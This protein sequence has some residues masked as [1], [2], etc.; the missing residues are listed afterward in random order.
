MQAN[1]FER[2][3]ASVEYAFSGNVATGS[4][5]VSCRSIASVSQFIVNFVPGTLSI[6]ILE[7]VGKVRIIASGDTT[8]R[9]CKLQMLMLGSS[10]GSTTLKTVIRSL[11]TNNQLLS[12]TPYDDNTPNL[13]DGSSYAT[14]GQASDDWWRFPAGE[15]E[16]W[17][18]SQVIAT[19]SGYNFDFF[20][21]FSNLMF[22]KYKVFYETGPGADYSFEMSGVKSDEETA[23]PVFPEADMTGDYIKASIYANS[24]GNDFYIYNGT[25]G[26]RY[27]TKIVGVN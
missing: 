18:G 1:A 15:V 27:I 24:G 16:L 21:G 26:N 2:F 3:E 6:D 22:K 14:Y 10:S 7:R 23:S 9:G 12:V 5:F 25:G 13:Q 20:S 19:A 11:G 4:F 8:P 17:S